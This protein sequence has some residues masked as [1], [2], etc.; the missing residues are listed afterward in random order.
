MRSSCVR[1]ALVSALLLACSPNPIADTGPTPA[2]VAPAT[3]A[4]AVPA[5]QPNPLAH[6]RPAAP[7]GS[8]ISVLALTDDGDAAISGDDLGD[9]RL[10]PTLDGKSPPIP[11]KGFRP[12]RLALGKAN[13]VLVVGAI[14]AAGSAWLARLTP[15]GVAIDRM[16]LPGDVR[17]D[18]IEIVGG[19]VIV[20][21][22]DQSI[23]VFDASGASRGRL[24][25]PAG[26]QLAEIVARRGMAMVLTGGDN[27]FRTLRV[28]ELDGAPRWGKSSALP[29][30]AAHVALAPGHARVAVLSALDR[31]VTVF[32]LASQ[33]SLGK[34]P[35][36]PQELRGRET[37]LGFL[38]D[39]HLAVLADQLAWWTPTTTDPWSTKAP[40]VSLETTSDIAFGDGVM[41]GGSNLL[42]SVTSTTKTR[43]LGYRD[44]PDQRVGTTPT[45]LTTTPSALRTLWLDDDLR[46]VRTFDLS[47]HTTELGTAAGS[48][49]GTTIS[50]LMAVGDR[51]VVVDRVDSTSGKF[52]FDFVDIDHL[53]TRTALGEFENLE[54][55]DFQDNTLLVFAGGKIERVRVDATKGTTERLAPL[56]QNTSNGTFQLTDPAR[57]N[58]VI[59]VSLYADDDGYHVATYRDGKDRKTPI[60]PTTSKTVS[61]YIFAFDRAGRRY[62]FSGTD[63]SFEVRD[64]DDKVVI[65]H[66]IKGVSG[67]AAVDHHGKMVAFIGDHEVIGVDVDGG[68]K[69]RTPVW[70][71]GTLMFSPDDKRLV[72]GTIA[73]YI[74]LDAATGQ[75]AALACGWNFGLWDTQPAVRNFGQAPVCAE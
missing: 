18:Q 25:A 51:Q 2:P 28:L 46:E 10:W 33:K 43:W 53:K 13:S 47:E 6:P 5:K 7:H 61:G 74:V 63:P 55:F 1:H 71:P 36:P 65:R 58:G 45:M 31:A 67:V 32:D 52:S 15:E 19:N 48:A 27:G 41:A 49:I 44:L 20:R 29:E 57:A 9:M 39:D 26:E 4:A 38:D 50:G 59:A 24:V 40:I 73:G 42:V 66:A 22:V 70:Q 54:R 64:V 12:V 3:P 17:A 69:W 14:D 75:R 8:T 68:E 56:V 34:Q 30:P 72:I 21:R 23:E 60:K 35:S 62:V 37:Q 11:V 16:Q